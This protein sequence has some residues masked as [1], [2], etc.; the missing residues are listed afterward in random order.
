MDRN[1]SRPTPSADRKVASR[2]G[3]VDRNTF[4]AG[5]DPPPS[6]ASREGGV[7]RNTYSNAAR[8]AARMSPP[9]RGAWIAT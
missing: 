1:S 7:D 6:V 2:E 5:P 4:F 3:G 8:N 9:A